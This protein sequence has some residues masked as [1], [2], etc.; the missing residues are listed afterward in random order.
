M[1]AAAPR[2]QAEQ[3]AGRA[4]RTRP[5]ICY[6]LYNAEY[7]KR[8]MAEVTPPEILR[9]SLLAAVLQLKS[10]PLQVAPAAE[11]PFSLPVAWHSAAAFAVLSG[12]TS[13][14]GTAT[15][16]CLGSWRCR[17]RHIFCRKLWHC[18]STS[19]IF[20]DVRSIQSSSAKRAAA[21]LRCRWTCWPSISWIAPP[22]APP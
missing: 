11:G 22:C 1:A 9:T 5:G 6:R 16:R 12:A 7:H 4:G 21:L 3:R 18:P 17:H 20:H 19:R 14:F 13:H 15:A 10:L 8:S 2:V